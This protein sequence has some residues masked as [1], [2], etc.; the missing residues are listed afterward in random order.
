[1]INAF[2]G[3]YRFLSNFYP[4]VVTYE[5]VA[6]PSVEHAYQ[7][8]K[9]HNLTLRRTIARYRYAADAKRAGKNLPLRDDWELVKRD[10]MRTLLAKKFA[11]GSGLAD[12]LLA[13]GDEM[14][15]E[16][17]WWNDTY[18]GVCDGVGQNWLGVLLMQR[19]TEL[20]GQSRGYLRT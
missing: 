13:T 11:V 19:R 12:Q 2:T 3:T 18:W 6:F 16:G 17:N 4:A 20:Q 8:A 1:M 9:T 15:V 7:A 5:G 14:L 10:T